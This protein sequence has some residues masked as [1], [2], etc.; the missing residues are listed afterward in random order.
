[1]RK[2]P[3]LMPGDAIAAASLSWGGPGTFPQRYAAGKRQLEQ[4]LGVRVAAVERQAEGTPRPG[5]LSARPR[6]LQS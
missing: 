3:K 4:T 6:S 2:P 1:M 5:R